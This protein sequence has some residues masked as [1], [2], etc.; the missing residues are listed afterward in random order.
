MAGLAQPAHRDGVGPM[1]RIARVRLQAPSDAKNVDAERWKRLRQLG[2]AEEAGLALGVILMAEMTNERTL[3]IYAFSGAQSIAVYH[4]EAEEY[5]ECGKVVSYV[6]TNEG[7]TYF[8]Y[9]QCSP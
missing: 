5:G 7:W 3:R 8:L 4:G 1:I 9:P 2:L 6:F